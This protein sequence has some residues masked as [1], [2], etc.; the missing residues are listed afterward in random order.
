VRYPKGARLK[1]QYVNSILNA[2]KHVFI[3]MLDLPVSFRDPV[4]KITRHPTYEV[5][6]FIGIT[7]HLNGYIVLSY[8]KNVAVKV[9]TKMLEERIDKIDDGLID[10]LC[11][12]ANMVTGVADTEMELD[13]LSYSL[14]D[15]SRFRNGLRYPAGSFVFSMSCAMD[16]G[17]FEVDIC[18]AEADTEEKS[19]ETQNFDS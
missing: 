15:V 13:N 16:S 12:I 4:T 19:R 2:V 1:V 9:A 6:T 18:L 11:E 14:P 8:P 10:A 5:S 17:D 7:G 3:S